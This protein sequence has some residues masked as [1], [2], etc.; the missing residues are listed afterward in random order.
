L[1]INS[2]DPRTSENQALAIANRSLDAL[3]SSAVLAKKLQQVYQKLGRSALTVFLNI[4]VAAFL[5]GRKAEMVFGFVSSSWHMDAR[6]TLSREFGPKFTGTGSCV[7]QQVHFAFYSINRLGALGATSP[8]SAAFLS[9]PWN[10]PARALSSDERLALNNAAHRLR[11]L[12]RLSER[13]SQ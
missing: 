1:A 6:R 9:F 12:G 11:A 13:A 5:I 10:Q 3:H 7:A 8:R 4:S 2:G